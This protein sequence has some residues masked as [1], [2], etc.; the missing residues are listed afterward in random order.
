MHSQRTADRHRP[1]QVAREHAAQWAARSVPVNESETQDQ[2]HQYHDDAGDPADESRYTLERRHFLQFA[3]SAES[4]RWLDSSHADWRVQ[5]DL[6]D[7]R[8]AR[9]GL[10]PT[11]FADHPAG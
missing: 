1:L 4:R 7:K 8:A 3:L 9:V 10:F 5:S 2:Q 11:L 6:S